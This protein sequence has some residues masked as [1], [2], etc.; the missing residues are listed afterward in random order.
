MIVGELP[1]GWFQAGSNH[2]GYETG[3][4]RGVDGIAEDAL[5]MRS[6]VADPPGFST[7]MREMP[8]EAYRGQHVT[9]TGEIKTEM[10]AG[11][12]QMWLR[13]DGPNNMTLGFDNMGNR[14]IAGKTATSPYSISMDVPREAERIA[15]GVLASGSGTTWF[16][17]LALS[18]STQGQTSATGEAPQEASE[19]VGELPSGWF[20]V[21][22]NIPGYESGTIRGIVGIEEAAVFMRSKVAKPEGFSTVMREMPA[23]AYQGKRVTLTGTIKTEMNPGKAQ[24]WMRIDGANNAVLGFDNMDNR[25]INGTTPASSYSITLDVPLEAIRIAYGVLAIG[26]GTTW[27]SPLTLSAKPSRSIVGE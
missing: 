16:S 22:S 26:E 17:P 1:S 15:F 18:A 24:M 8:A 5:F 25:P 20:Q 14:P 19:R 13:I 12:A 21:G 9:L 23:A 27:F 2:E 11:K 10:N 3:T 4:A 6:K 7:V